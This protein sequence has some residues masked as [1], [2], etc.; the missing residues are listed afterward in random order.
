MGPVRRVAASQSDT[1]SSASL[2]NPDPEKHVANVAYLPIQADRYGAL[3][4]QIYIQGLDLTGVPM[5]AQVRLGGDVPGVPLVDLQTVTNGNAQGL[6]LVG[7]TNDNG[8]P[9]SHVEMVINEATIEGL[10]YAGELGSE[11]ALAWDWQVTL[12]GRKQRIARGEFVITGDGVTGADNAPANRVA[13]W[14]NSFS[15]VAGMRTGA[16]LTF[17]D[18]TIAVS[19]DGADL[20]APLT[21]RAEDSAARSEAGRTGAELAAA[22]AIAS[23]RYFPTRAA[24]EAAST[25]NQLFSTDD[26]AGS[27]IYYRRTAGSSVEIGRAVTPGA[28]AGTGGAA[29]VGFGGRSVASKLRDWVSVKDTQ[30]A[31]GAVGDGVTDDTAAI[32]AALDSGASAIVFPDSDY[33]FSGLTI[34]NPFQ[35]LFGPGAHLIRTDPASTILVDKPARG[36]HFTQLRISTQTDGMAG[37]NVTVKAPDFRAWGVDNGGCEGNCYAF[38]NCG[39]GIVMN[40]GSLHSTGTGPDDYDVDIYD[41]AGGDTTLYCFA[42][43]I[44]TNQHTGGW[45]YRGEVGSCAMDKIEFGKLTVLTGGSVKVDQ[46]RIGGKTNIQSGFVDI[47]CS[48]L[49]DDVQIGTDGQPNIGSI[50]L[51]PGNTLKAGK[52]ITIAKN[53]IESIFFLSHIQKGGG[54]VDIRNYDNDIYHNAID[55]S[56]SIDLG[57]E[58][59]SPTKGNAIVRALLTA[60]GRDRT[61]RLS[62]QAG[63]TTNFGSGAYFTVAAPFSSRGVATN[64][65]RAVVSGQA[66]IWGAYLRDGTNQIKFALAQGGNDVSATSPVPLG[67]GTLIEFSITAEQTF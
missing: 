22:T 28:L 58:S 64:V 15:P 35:R 67:N 4:R 43:N 63:S 32:Q 48:D 44:V 49:N 26:G 1:L 3:V 47:D 11:T 36:V 60:N 41:E 65:A 25:A 17:G 10:P 38:V 6:R 40:G 61:L 42:S 7:V 51:G 12:A 19:V 5:R 66:Y 57:A 55:V 27:L 45:R 16:T 29:M 8:L 30:F 21:K 50:R 39:G 23:S 56:A 62:F 59:G 33:C 46:C 34:S 24:G 18:E 53:V 52:K 14:A 13:G 31:G 54:L 2:K 9:T 20:V 37:H